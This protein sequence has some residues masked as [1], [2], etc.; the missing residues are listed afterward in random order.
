MSVVAAPV[1]PN[2]RVEA[3]AQLV[4]LGRHKE[5]EELLQAVLARAPGHA[6]A[7]N[8]WASIALARRDGDSAYKILAPACTA[9]PDNPRLLSNLG[10]AHLMLARP[11]EAV[12]CLERAVALAPE[13][14][15]VRLSLAQFLMNAGDVARATAEIETVLRQH[16]QNADALSQLGVCA[17]ALGDAARAEAAWYRAIQIDP[18]KAEAHHNL[19]VLCA[20]TGRLEEAARLAERAHL[21]AP[22]DLTKR[23]Q[24]ARCLAAIG[25]FEGANFHCKQVLMVAPDHLPATD[26][27]A[28][29]T[30]T[31]GAVPAGIE[32]LSYYVRRH[33]KDPDAIL[34]L[35]GALRFVG[36]MPQALN[37][38][39]Q[40]L[41]IAPKHSLAHRLQIDL[42][43]TLGRF[44]EAWLDSAVAPAD[45]PRLIIAPKGTSTIDALVF[46]RF[47][48]DLPFDR[49]RIVAQAEPVVTRL[50]RRINRVALEEPDPE[51][52]ENALLLHTLPAA[53]G[54]ERRAMKPAGR[55]LNPEPSFL[56]RWRDA[57]AEWPRPLIGVDWERFPPGLRA[58]DVLS[59]V[60][61]TGT[62]VSLADDPKR[63]QLADWPNV[64][65]AG[66][67]IRGADDLIAAMACLDAF[68]G[69]DGLPLHVA[70]A[71][72]LP[73]VAVSACGYPWHLAAEAGRS[74]WYSSLRVA[75]QSVPG[76]WGDAAAAAKENLREILTPSNETAMIQ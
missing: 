65:D 47:I 75:R 17:V 58:A 70:G 23:V 20:S 12:V 32:T 67:H 16:P 59:I 22:L 1:D 34:A 45:L 25:D 43:L 3:A 68:I 63:R 73:G 49:T 27:F 6:D 15:E 40:A 9:H 66:A 72:D 8:T 7:L 28:R 69:P 11:H 21:W 54:V 10:L 56:E 14:A 42:L 55:F 57:L 50:L 36:R 35:A 30:L 64:V 39:D 51:A 46:G 52:N 2:E 24:L 18:K 61:E 26:L 48:A 29:L 37:F 74:I 41:A 33:P 60:G 76:K 4:A 13:D 53:L 62:V 31:R 44:G 5:A 38:V 19:S 71:L